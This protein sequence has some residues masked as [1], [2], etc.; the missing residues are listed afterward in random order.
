MWTCSLAFNHSCCW[1]VGLHIWLLP[2]WPPWPLHCRKERC[3]WPACMKISARWCSLLKL[4]TQ[5]STMYVPFQF[6]NQQCNELLVNGNAVWLDA[7]GGGKL[8]TSGCGTRLRVWRKQTNFKPGAECSQLLYRARLRRWGLSAGPTSHKFAIASFSCHCSCSVSNNWMLLVFLSPPGMPSAFF[9]AVLRSSG[10]WPNFDK[11]CHL[12]LVVLYQIQCEMVAWDWTRHHR[13]F[14]LNTSQEAFP[15]LRICHRTALDKRLHLL[16]CVHQAVSTD[17]KSGWSKALVDLKTGVK[18][19]CFAF[20]SQ[21][22][23]HE[24][25]AF[26]KSE[27]LTMGTGSKAHIQL[28]EILH[29]SAKLTILPESPCFSDPAAVFGAAFLTTCSVWTLKRRCDVHLHWCL[30]EAS[31]VTSQLRKSKHWTIQKTSVAFFCSATCFVCNV[32]PYEFASAHGEWLWYTSLTSRRAL[33]NLSAK[34]NS[35]NEHECNCTCLKKFEQNTFRHSNSTKALWSEATSIFC[36]LGNLLSRR[37]H[38]R[39]HRA[40]RRHLD[41]ECNCTIGR[42]KQQT[43]GKCFFNTE[44]V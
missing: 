22:D 11:G 27:T 33:K 19:G 21:T 15:W 26:F 8:K 23:T 12:A 44:T 10:I 17:L 39:C 24:S 3:C 4:S 34:R 43:T 28:V 7:A 29:P 36:Q 35:G 6:A 2:P 40:R 1:G 13:G 25:W 41:S 9:S 31:T 5:A 32:K 30:F 42:N 16:R 37:D 20:A 38:C 18:Q 14:D